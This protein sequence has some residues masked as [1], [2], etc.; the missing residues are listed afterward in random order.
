[1][2]FESIIYALKHPDTG[3]VFYIGA[4]SE[5]LKRRWMQH[6]RALREA[7]LGKRILNDRLKYLKDLLP[8]KALIEVIIV[9]PEELMYEEEVIQ[10]AKYRESGAS[11]VNGTDGGIGGGACRYLSPER[12]IEF[13]DKLSR[14]NKGKKK[15]EGFAE[16][17][18]VSRKGKENPAA[19]AYPIPVVCIRGEF[20]KIFYHA[21]EIDAFLG[22][23]HASSNVIKVLKG[24]LKYRPYNYDWRYYDEKIDFVD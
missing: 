17:M 21:F 23:R 24:K 20:K 10:I 19:K 8:K 16:N 5:S 22:N 4:T 1:M 12:Q 6:Y 2:N 9:V 18:A 7:E 11:L 14:A 13:R 3:D 15:P